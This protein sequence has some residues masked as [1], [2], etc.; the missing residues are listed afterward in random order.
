M[1]NN[2][3][4]AL[5]II[6]CAMP[7]FGMH[8]ELDKSESDASTKQYLVR[9]HTQE[10]LSINPQLFQYCTYSGTSV[11]VIDYSVPKRYYSGACVPAI[12]E[13][14][15]H[16]ENE[17]GMVNNYYVKDNYPKQLHLFSTGIH[18]TIRHFDKKSNFDRK[19][20]TS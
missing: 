8:K 4:V 19:S 10:S 1:K 6:S 18:R 15:A 14:L 16:W 9:S 13:R 5:F 2:I 17:P 3:T 12:E 7:I 20:F 11:P